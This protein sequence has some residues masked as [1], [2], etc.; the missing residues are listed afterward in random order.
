MEI[1]LELDTEKAAKATIVIAATY[2]LKQV[3]EGINYLQIT[4][5][6]TIALIA[7]IAII[8]GPHLAPKA[9]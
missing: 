5:A 3:S 7:I 4:F 9:K 6:S 2:G 8:Y 1:K